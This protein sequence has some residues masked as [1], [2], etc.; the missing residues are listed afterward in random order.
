MPSAS[1]GALGTAFNGSVPS[2][3]AH[4]PTSQFPL[5]SETAGMTQALPGMPKESINK[6]T[7]TVLQ[8][9]LH[10]L[11][12]PVLLPCIHSGAPAGVSH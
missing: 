8:V 2:A 6:A 9:G 12:A 3:L 10:Q 5:F 7:T 1:K 4:G 11:R